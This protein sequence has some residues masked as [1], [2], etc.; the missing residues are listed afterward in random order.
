MPVP[1]DPRVRDE[2]EATRAS[3][4]RASVWIDSGQ[5]TLARPLIDED[6]AIATR[7]RYPPLEAETLLTRGRL[8]DA[9][10]DYG[11]SVA[12]YQLAA[13]S[14]DRG[15]DDR[16]RFR[17]WARLI[18]AL[19]AA[20]KLDEAEAQL[21]AAAAA[22]ERAGA[23]SERVE[24]WDG[25]QARVAYLRGRVGDAEALYRD[26][27]GRARARGDE[28]AVGELLQ[29]LVLTT[30]DVAEPSVTLPLAEESLAIAVREY[31]EHH[32][33]PARR[34]ASLA[35]ILLLQGKLDDA[36][37]RATHAYELLL[38]VYGPDHGD[39][40]AVELT[41]GGI[42]RQLGR[43]DEARTTIRHC[44]GVLRARFG[45]HHFWVADALTDLAKIERRAGAF[46]AALDYAR[47]AQAILEATLGPNTDGLV[48]SHHTIALILRDQGKLDAAEASL[49][50]GV[51][52]GQR[53]APNNPRLALFYSELGSIRLERDD[54]RGAET[55][56]DRAVA[57]F[58]AGSSSPEY[59]AWMRMDLAHAKA[60]LGKW[61]E[62]LDLATSAREALTA[63]EDLAEADGLIA[64]ARR[65][66][67]PVRPSPK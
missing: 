48:A 63:P 33:E 58:Q 26:A 51:E 40:A 9:A 27:L 32:P 67:G 18:E 43:N 61:R 56:L 22:L 36:L 45:E 41:V 66:V 29:A 21:P 12:T 37:A 13:A 25:T 24:L 16:L 44:L 5:F 3:L 20:G 10:A 11:R 62:V 15:R 57:T 46:P 47:Q 39:V 42:Q 55:W 28:R 23:D 35:R 14:A 19:G 65:H 59:L 6:V 17:A 2:I 52:L 4:V 54:A 64:T 1:A 60:A 34:E 49:K 30:T 38:G 8:E 50:A 53:I 7:L 31:G